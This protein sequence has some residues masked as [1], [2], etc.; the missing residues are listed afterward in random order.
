LEVEMQ[1]AIRRTKLFGERA[2]ELGFV[3]E[4]DVLEALRA[5]HEAK[6][7]FGKHLF[8]GEILLL[9]RKLSA[10]QIADILRESSEQPEEAEDVHGRRFFG[11]VAI[12]MGFCTAQ[13]VF[14]ALNVQRAED[15]KGGHHRL[16][17]EILFERGY[18]TKAQVEQV[19]VRMVRG[20]AQAG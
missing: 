18:L 6:I 1:T 4:E 3:D 19:V 7:L 12:D 10:R 17:G 9:Q 14:D 16:V 15:G 2:V 5:Q 20:A 11:D 8:L 13:Q